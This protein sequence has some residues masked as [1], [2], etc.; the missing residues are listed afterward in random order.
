VRYEVAVEGFEMPLNVR[1]GA[2]SGQALAKG[3]EVRLHIDPAEV[4]IFPTNG[5]KSP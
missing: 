5:D 3:A 2:G 1:S 4:L